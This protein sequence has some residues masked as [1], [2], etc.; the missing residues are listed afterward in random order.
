MN[1][2]LRASWRAGRARL[3]AYLDDH[4][5]LA[6]GLLDLYETGLERHDLEESSRL[7]RATISRFED[8]ERGGFF[9]TSHDH[10]T[11][12]ARPRSLRDSALPSGAGVAAETLL[13]LA[14][15]LDDRTFREAAIRALG[16]CRPALERAPSAFASHLAAADLAE[17]P[18]PEIAT[19]G[20]PESGEARRDAC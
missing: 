7:A 6:R 2:R 4:A 19:A 5:F 18:A 3:E 20:D 10:E 8:P 17:G 9:F 16:A 12:I 15:H 11:P 14:S 13:R 1:G